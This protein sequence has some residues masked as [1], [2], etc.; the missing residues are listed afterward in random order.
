M[1]SVFSRLLLGSWCVIGCFAIESYGEN[2]P[3]FRGSNQD[4][5]STSRLPTKWKDVDNEAE[6]I[7]WKIKTSGEGW[8]QPLV[9]QDQVIYT[10]A[11]PV[12]PDRAGATKPENY[13]GGYGRDR[14]DLVKVVYQYRVVSLDRESGEEKWSSVVKT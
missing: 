10:E 1:Q 7:R 12:D 5:S 14:D 9:W 8:S 11:V 6:G 4:A 2:Y 3:Q 13:N